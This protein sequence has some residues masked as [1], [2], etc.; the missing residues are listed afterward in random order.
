MSAGT[1]FAG[2]AQSIG[3]YQQQA[4]M[5][6]YNNAIAKQQYQQQLA[7]A[8]ATDAAEDRVYQA[9]LKAQEAAQNAYYRQLDTNQAEANR[10][11][12]ASQQK[13]QERRKAAGFSAQNAMVAAI[14]AQGQTL[15]T[16]KSGQSFLLSSMDAQR[17]LGFE[18]AS[19][20]ETLFDA[21]RAAGTEMQGILLDQ[22]SANVAAWN[23]LP[24]APLA[25]GASFLPLK[26]I[27]APGPSGLAL[28]GALAGNVMDASTT[29]ISTYK[30]LKG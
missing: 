19:I 24:A 15:A 29:G 9:R 23:N 17:Q 11:M 10:A 21:A 22:E 20:D 12:L 7:I 28:A 25:P 4:A 14:Q 8:V 27:D 2:A 16:G 1:L 3:Q 13:L 6:A 18:Q 5:T 30:T 26:P